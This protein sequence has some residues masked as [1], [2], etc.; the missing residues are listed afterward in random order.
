MKDQKL[1]KSYSKFALIFQWYDISTVVPVHRAVHAALSK[2]AEI[3]WPWKKA[4][5]TYADTR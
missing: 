5:Q 3:I 1:Q 4:S 2:L